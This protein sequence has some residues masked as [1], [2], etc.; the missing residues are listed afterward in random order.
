MSTP[1]PPSFAQFFSSQNH[2][3]RSSSG[4]SFAAFPQSTGPIYDP[5]QI[6]GEPDPISRRG[7]T[8]SFHQVA[9]G[10]NHDQHND[11]VPLPNI[12]ST[13]LSTA[14]LG[15]AQ[16]INSGAS[17]NFRQAMYSTP[18][19]QQP[20]QP[21]PHWSNGFSQYQPSSSDFH[22]QPMTYFA[23]GAGLSYP[24]TGAGDP[25]N[26]DPSSS[27]SNDAS[28]WGADFVSDAGTPANFGVEAEAS[29][30]QRS[31]QF[32]PDEQAQINELERM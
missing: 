22:P 2:Q 21:I 12:P 28:T 19:E 17:Q 10:D 7:S 16:P 14:P 29:P 6:V 1:S 23:P 3:R 4:N 31:P 20:S 24:M 15:G 26:Y 30:W 32:S 13:I 27:F 18:G 9:G 5:S 8:A 11:S 25:L